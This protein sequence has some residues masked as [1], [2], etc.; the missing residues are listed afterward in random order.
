MVNV[1]EFTDNTQKIISKAHSLAEENGNPMIYPLHVAIAI[2]QDGGIG[3]SL[4]E[5]FCIEKQVVDR[6]LSKAL[7][8]LPSQHPPPDNINFSHGMMS[9]LRKAETVKKDAGDALMAVDHLLVAL[10]DDKQVAELLTEIGL[11][12]DLVVNAIK[13]VKGNR[14]VSSKN[15]EEHYEALEKYAVNMVKLAEQN[16]LDPIIGRDEEIRRTIQVLCRRT[17]NNPVLIGH[18]GVGK[19]AIVEGLA[20]RIVRGDVPESLK[21]QVYSLSMAA[22]VAGASYRGQFEERLTE[23]IKTVEESNGGIILF[24][25]ELHLA[26]GAGGNQGQLDAANILKP[27]LARGQIRVIGATTLEEYQ[28]H[29][30]KDAAFERRFQQVMVREPTVPDTISILRGLKDKYE[31]FHGIKIADASIVAAATLAKRYISHRFLP[32]SAIDVLDEACATVRIQRDSR[33]EVIDMLERKKL[34]L[35]IEEHAL[36]KE[37]DPVSKQRLAKIKEELSKVEEQLKPLNMKL[38]NERSRITQIQQ[39]NQKLDEL[40]GKMADAERRR[41][42]QLAA[43]IKYFAIPDLEKQIAELKAAEEKNQIPEA[44]RM[45]QEVV[46]EDQVCQIIAKWTGIPVNRLNASE[47]QRL[48]QLADHLRRKVVGQDEAVEAVAD[49]VLRN[50]SGLSRANAPYG[51]FLFLGSSGVGKTQ[52]AKALAFELFDDEKA[53]VRID[54]SEYQQSHT[55][56]RLIGSP[57]GYVGYESGGQLTEKVRR[58]PYCVVLFDEIEKADL[59]VLNILLQV[60]DD[61]RLTDGKGRVVDFSN[62]VIIMTSNIGSHLLTEAIAQTGTVSQQNKDAVLR[63]V[64]QSLRPEFINRIDNII[65]FNPLT[66]ADL[67]KIVLI[68][69]ADVKKRLKEQK[70]IDLVVSEA[71]A[72]HIGQVAYDPNFGARPLKR[73][74]EKNIV[75]E[76]SKM[77]IAGTVVDHCVVTID[78]LDGNLTFNVG[79][80]GGDEMAVEEHL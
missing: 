40:K 55:V 21:C 20:Q 34:Q 60:L 41:D 65:V 37:S 59:N 51:S 36:N 38:Q 33:P 67:E 32:D 5:R 71:A 80:K 61:G 28:Q 54:M 68:Q 12:K 3:K 10:Y 23:V 24:I 53:V 48:L 39:L 6:T 70:D 19:T 66:D 30:E 62:C 79:I 74:L 56:N 15:A 2:F 13:S 35:E 73:Y 18:P 72:S 63:A 45:V 49:A 46:T 43:D 25:D 77:I 76:L 75:T 17:K 11:K 9:V 42:L 52:L 31:A 1:E 8:K 69:L 16:K 29:V 58:N 22:L 50:R 47:S 26:L 7:V 64:H 57:P 27:A 4:L 78:M 44:D 14:R